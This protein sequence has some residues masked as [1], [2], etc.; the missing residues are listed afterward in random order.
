[1]Y[2]VSYSI[3]FLVDILD[4]FLISPESTD[5]MAG[6]AVTLFCVHSGS[7]PA[8]QMSW[9]KDG[10]T[11]S[12]SGSITITT[13]V[14]QHAT[15]PQTSSS[16][17]ISP[18]SDGDAGQYECVATNSLLPGLPVRSSMATLTVSGN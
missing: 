5:A 11:L 15:P 3:T 10:A 8:A 17:S 2:F 18:V 1:M 9:I 12:S 16:V 4:S 14:L 13:G 7:L 6:T